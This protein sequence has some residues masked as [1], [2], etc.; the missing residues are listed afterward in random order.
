MSTWR[1]PDIL[2]KSHAHSDGKTRAKDK[3]GL[4]EDLDESVEEAADKRG[5]SKRA[6]KDRPPSSRPG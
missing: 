6:G 3:R 1:P 2:R 5:A 4:R